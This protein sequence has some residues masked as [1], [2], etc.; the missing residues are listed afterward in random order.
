MNPL[1]EEFLERVQ[2][3]IL[4]DRIEEMLSHPSDGLRDL[5][6]AWKDHPIKRGP[7][8]Y[9]VL[10]WAAYL[11]QFIQAIVPPEGIYKPHGFHY[12]PRQEGPSFVGS[13]VVRQVLE[14]FGSDFDLG[15]PVVLVRESAKIIEEKQE[16]NF[17]HA[18]LLCDSGPNPLIFHRMVH[19]VVF[20]ERFYQFFDLHDPGERIVYL[21][22]EV[23]L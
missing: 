7:T 1:N 11:D 21:P 19:P 16:W 5:E 22:K 3:R 9:C 13:E 14:K 20:V 6:E 15:G 10:A 17:I 12:F 23:P 4:T 2:G 18:G 8:C